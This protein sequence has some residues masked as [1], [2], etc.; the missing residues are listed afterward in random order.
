MDASNSPSLSFNKILFALDFSPGS[1]LALP[2]AIN[3]AAHYHSKLFVSHVSTENDQSLLP[4]SRAQLKELEAGAEAGLLTTLDKFD[5]VPHEFLFDH[6]SICSTLAEV[7]DKCKV[8]LIV[9]GTHGWRGI[10]K[11]LKGSTAEELAFLAS[12][13]VLTVG[14]KV[15][16][17]PEFKCILC[18]TAVSETAALALLYTFSL[19]HSY[20]ASVTALLNNPDAHQRGAEAALDAFGFLRDRLCGV[21]GVTAQKAEVVVESGPA[22]ECILRFAIARNC[23]LIVV[24]IHHSNSARARIAAHLPGATVYEV[25]S[26]ARC[27]V[28]T[29]PLAN[30]FD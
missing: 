21:Y 18:P 3:I 1:L 22:V 12:R 2:F 19:G 27:P 9:I 11:L 6:G 15:E 4:G 25:V 17:Q 24:G 10:K 30:E 5:E 23:D 16:S 8:D 28:L 14:P 20:G 26:Q 13:P 29:V 7:A